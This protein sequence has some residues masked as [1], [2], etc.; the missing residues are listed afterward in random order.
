[1]K[2]APPP[3]LQS[4]LSVVEISLWADL[5]QPAAGANATRYSAGAHTDN[6]A[7]HGGC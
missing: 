3:L 1:M 7:V 6:A 5:A 2:F 4:L